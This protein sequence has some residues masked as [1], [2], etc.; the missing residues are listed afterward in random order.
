MQQVVL[1]RTTISQLA[2]VAARIIIIII[3]TTKRRALVALK[4]YDLLG[5]LVRSRRRTPRTI[6]L[7][8]VIIN[9]AMVLLTIKIVSVELRMNPN[10]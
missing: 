6:H 7:N 9:L 3:T 4:I 2:Q 1:R 5:Y 8:Q 10:Q